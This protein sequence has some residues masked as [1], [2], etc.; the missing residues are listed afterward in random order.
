M[1]ALE[2][3]FYILHLFT[4]KRR[5]NIVYKKR[6]NILFKYLNN[7]WFIIVAINLSM[8][9]LDYTLKMILRR[10]FPDGPAVTDHQRLAL[11][12]LIYPIVIPFILYEEK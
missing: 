9:L 7:Y 12:L 6:E 11:C 1:Y 2:I 10:C 5:Y 8:C 3:K 4:F